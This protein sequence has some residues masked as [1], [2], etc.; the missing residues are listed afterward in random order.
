MGRQ[1]NKVI[2]RKRRV[3]YIKRK[4]ARARAKMPA[5]KKAA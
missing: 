4:N 3:N 1:S 2:K 5:P